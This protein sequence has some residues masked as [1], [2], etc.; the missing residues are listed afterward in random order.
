M[1]QLDI[2]RKQIRILALNTIDAVLESQAINRIYEKICIN[3]QFLFALSPVINYLVRKLS[4]WIVPKNLAI[5]IIMD[6]NRR[7]ARTAGISRKQGHIQGY[8]HLHS[9][10][11]YMNLIQCKAVGFFAFGKKNY[12]RSKEEVTDIMSILENAFKE[13]NEKKEY[14]ELCD[15]VMITGD[16]DSMPSNIIPHVTA[17]NERSRKKKDCFIFMSYSSLD[18]YVNSATDGNT[19]P[20]DIIIRPGGE[21]RM[22]DF[23]LCNASKQAM[24]SFLAVKWP[25]LT[26]MHILL[27]IIKYVIEL[28]L[29]V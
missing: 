18:E 2:Y 5:A 12:N 13:L 20:F 9:I 8:T 3:M 4:N 23:L 1:A 10:L 25:V 24:L 19:I 29:R 6:G 26:P 28:P 21:K 27:V 17:I 7:Y 15:R 14:Q 11:E 16:I 22:S